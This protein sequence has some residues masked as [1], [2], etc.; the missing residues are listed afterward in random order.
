MIVSNP[1][2]MER[3]R[4]QASYEPLVLVSLCFAIKLTR[5]YYHSFQIDKNPSVCVC[6]A[7]HPMV[8]CFILDRL[9]MTGCTD[10][11]TSTLTFPTISWV[12]YLLYSRITL[13][14]PNLQ[15]FGGK[16][17]SL[18]FPHPSTI[19]KVFKNLSIQF[20]YNKFHRT[21]QRVCDGYWV[22]GWLLR[23]ILLFALV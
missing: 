13:V 11:Q 22:C 23:L 21:S 17:Q 1:E 5:K 19:R 16:V 9:I 18:E 12:V 15:Q 10:Q 8:Q 20:K 14:K 6:F 7:G 2:P 4:G 3:R